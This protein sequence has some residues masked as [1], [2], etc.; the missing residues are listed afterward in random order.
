MAESP[1]IVQDPD[2]LGG[3]PS[4]RG[5]RISVELICERVEDGW[6]IEEVMNSYP[7]LTRRDVLEAL[8]YARE[9]TWPDTGGEG[10]GND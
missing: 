4:V 7:R 8:A 1:T 5:T 10:P 3:K 2:V 6:S 9:T